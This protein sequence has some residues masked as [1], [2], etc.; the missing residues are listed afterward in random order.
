MGWFIK[1]K[2]LAHPEYCVEFS[3]KHQE[4]YKEKQWTDWRCGIVSLKKNKSDWIHLNG[5]I[6]KKTMKECECDN[7]KKSILIDKV[8]S[9]FLIA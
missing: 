1:S 6:W 2:M 4:R 9:V 7:D 5:L 8:N 3:L